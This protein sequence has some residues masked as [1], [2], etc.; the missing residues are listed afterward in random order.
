MD[1]KQTAS[2][3]RGMMAAEKTTK[4][5]ARDV[6]VFLWRRLMEPTKEEDQP[7]WKKAKQLDSVWHVGQFLHAELA[8]EQAALQR[9]EEEGTARGRGAVEAHKDPVYESAR[10]PCRLTGEKALAGRLVTPSGF[11]VAKSLQRLTWV[12][13]IVSMPASKRARKTRVGSR[14]RPLT[15]CA[16]KIRG[17]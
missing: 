12:P 6:D 10:A 4:L 8:C 1:W 16:K 7:Q 5:Y 3:S 15:D 2:G 9:I 11:N 17:M 14:R 13:S